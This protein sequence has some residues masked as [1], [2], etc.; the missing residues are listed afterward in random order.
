MLI[1]DVFFF[2]W[3]LKFLFDTIF[4]VFGV[5]MKYLYLLLVAI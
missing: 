3:K 2:Y 4:I 1:D 5:N